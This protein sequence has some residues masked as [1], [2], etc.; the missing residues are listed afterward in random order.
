MSRI[1]TFI[2]GSAVV[3]TAGASA[4]YAGSPTQAQPEPVVAQP[5]TPV[6]AGTDWS[7]PY[8]GASLGF[9]SWDLGGA[10]GEGRNEGAFLGYDYD[11]GNY[12][13]G[14]E[15]QYIGNDVTVGGTALNGMARLKGKLGYDAGPVL[16]Y[17]TA[18][19]AWADS[20]AGDGDGYVAGVGM[21][22]QFDNGVAV[23]AEYL[24]NEFSDFANTGNTLTGNTIEARISYRF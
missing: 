14:G 10:S 5:V 19:Y 20:S 2:I 13:A 8:Y 11:F 21:D 16:L 1:K 6:V 9:G 12:V 18:G 22:Y 17:G 23:G 24:Y 7:G 15:L 3:V 4:A